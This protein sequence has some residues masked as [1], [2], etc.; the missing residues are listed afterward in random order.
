MNNLDFVQ[1]VDAPTIKLLV[2]LKELQEDLNYLNDDELIQN[3]QKVNIEDPFNF[4]DLKGC[5]AQQE[6]SNEYIQPSRNQQVQKII[7]KKNNQI[8]YNHQKSYKCGYCDKIYIQSQQLG[9]HISRIHKKTENQ[10]SLASSFQLKED[11]QIQQ[12]EFDF[13]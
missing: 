8:V 9:G 11:N 12:L 2:L 6:Y 3:N 10:Q 5:T 4:L 13:N 1:E 7:T